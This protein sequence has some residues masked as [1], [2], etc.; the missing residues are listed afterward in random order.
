MQQYLIYVL[1]IQYN[2]H[3][4]HSEIL[5]LFVGHWCVAG[6]CKP[7]LLGIHQLQNLLRSLQVSVSSKMG[8]F[9]L[10]DVLEIL[11]AHIHCF[12]DPYPL[13]SS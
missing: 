9:G 4:G 1:L 11:Q 5:T 3:P 7:I 8:P 12:S 2:I 10:H 13:V 6:C